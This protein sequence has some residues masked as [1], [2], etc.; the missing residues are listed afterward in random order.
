MANSETSFADR[1]QRGS[2]LQAALAG[3]APPFAPADPLLLPAAF[4]TFLEGLG[5]MNQAVAMA[6]AEWKDAAASRSAL[7]TEIKARALRAN[8]RVKSNTAWKA[9]VAA[10]KTAADNLRGYRT[11]APKLPVNPESDA[12][13][14]PA[15]SR[16]KT[17]QSFG[18]IKN[19]LDKL[20]AALGRVSG[21]DTGAPVD[22][23]I[24]SLSALATQLD[25][26][27]QMVAG[28]EQAL[29]AARGPRNAAY[30]IDLAGSPC[31][32]TRML[33]AKEATKSQ[34]GTASAEY[35]QVKGI[36]V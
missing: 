31:L 18:D 8:S 15:R 3:F 25:G 29:A 20:I 30:D 22:V 7:V 16:A 33:A 26:L 4:T 24:A 28:K 11:A 2:S 32:R 35:A 27:N 23:T 12:P 13:A 17:D 14:A 9:Q 34:Y 6:E 19:L 1:L 21:Y 10:V 5:G 36:K